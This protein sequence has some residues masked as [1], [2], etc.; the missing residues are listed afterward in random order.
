M[1]DELSK[2]LIMQTLSDFFSLFMDSISEEK[3]RR[4]SPLKVPISIAIK[5]GIEKGI[6]RAYKCEAITE[7][8]DCI[9]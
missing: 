7:Y 2:D 9:C 3:R 5:M 4:M 6:A 8:K 1:D